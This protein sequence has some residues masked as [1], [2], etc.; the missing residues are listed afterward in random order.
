MRLLYYMSRI[1]EDNC[2]TDAMHRGLRM[3]RKRRRQLRERRLAMD[4]KPDDHENEE[5]RLK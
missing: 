4:H 5:I 3:D 1:F 2:K